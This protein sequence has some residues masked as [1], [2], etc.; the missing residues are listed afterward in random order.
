MTGIILAA[1]EGSRMN[2]PDGPPK[3]LMELWGQTLLEHTLNTLTSLGISRC[4]V[5]GGYRGEEIEQFILRKGLHRRMDLRVVYNDRWQEG[6]AS[7]ILAARP[8]LTD[9]RFVVVMGDHLFDPSGLQGFLKV[10]G[11][12][13]GVFDSNPRFVD[14]TEA[15]KARSRRGHVVALSKDLTEYKYVDTGLFI[16]SQRIFPFIEECLADGVGTFNEVKRRWVAQGHILHIFDCQGAFW[17]DVD[18]PE[19]LARAREI[20][21]NRLLKPRDGI[22]AR[23]LNRR[24]SIPVSRWLVR[25]TF[26]TP[27]QITFGV[28]I[29]S[30]VAAMMF[31]WGSG[32]PVVL[33][34]L[35]A[36]VASVLDGCDGEVAR[37]RQMASPHGA[38]LDAVLDRWADALLIGGMTWGA[39]RVLEQPWVWP[40]GFLGLAGT[41]MISYSE[42]RYEGAFRETPRFGDGILAKRD[43]RLFLMMLGGVTGHLAL[44][45]ALLAIL[46]LAESLR[47]GIVVMR[48]SPA[49]G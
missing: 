33:A 49:V 45:L 31:G 2:N 42:A 13:V 44:A 39:W 1:G 28:F 40:L 5:V 46:T 48:G 30:V 6:N 4:I 16:C 9:D 32:I 15:T 43:V 41:L 7:S 20:M 36:Q 18:T 8:Y 11:D 23:W 35:L 38:W 26:L 37:L 19:D 22:V 12:F 17:M 25:H 47:R 3:V 14:I 27:N 29:L 10:R 24:L 34:G 21:K